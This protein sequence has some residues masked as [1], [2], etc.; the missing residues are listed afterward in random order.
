MRGDFTP[1]TP[2]G[3]EHP[4]LTGA[5]LGFTLV[6]ETNVATLQ[7]LNGT[8]VLRPRSAQLN[9]ADLLPG[10]TLASKCNNK[11]VIPFS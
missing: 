11:T 10:G 6:N 3:M 4:I 8:Y 7:M 9:P 2:T 5:R 1:R